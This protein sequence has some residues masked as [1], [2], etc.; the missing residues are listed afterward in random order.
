LLSQ[1]LYLA[2]KLRVIPKTPYPHL[3]WGKSRRTQSFVPITEKP[4]SLIMKMW[5]V[6]LQVSSVN[7]SVPLVDE[8][9]RVNPLLLVKRT[10]SLREL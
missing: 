1:P 7:L 4:N 6:V 9:D 8:I 10:E 3:L 2:D 5:K